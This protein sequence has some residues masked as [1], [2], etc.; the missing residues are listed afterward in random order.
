MPRRR[1]EVPDPARGPGSDGH[2]PAVTHG[3]QAPGAPELHPHVAAVLD[4]VRPYVVAVGAVAAFGTPAEV[5]VPV[6]FAVAWRLV[7]GR[8]PLERLLTWSANWAAG[9]SDR[10]P[11]PAV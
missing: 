6:V 3:E 1:G 10:A 9:L 8:G 11:A 7:T 2:V 5:A 4:D